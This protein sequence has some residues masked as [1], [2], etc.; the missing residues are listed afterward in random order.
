M[1]PVSTLYDE[2]IDRPKLTERKKNPFE[3]I[4]PPPSRGIGTIIP[5]CKLDILMFTQ[6]STRLS[7]TYKILITNLYLRVFG[8][9]A[10]V[11]PTIAII[12]LFSIPKLID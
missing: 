3:Y 1:I 2:F 6:I 9:H 12:F 4:V 8:D 11:E 10:G 5:S 7:M